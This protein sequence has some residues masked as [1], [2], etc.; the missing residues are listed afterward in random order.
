[1]PAKTAARRKAVARVANHAQ[2]HPDDAAGRRLLRRDL[3]AAVLEERAAELTAY[4]K[5]AV[6]AAPPLTSEQR[7]RLRALL[8]P[9]V[10]LTEDGG[11]P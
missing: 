5:A 2:N 7:A 11:A 6:A 10:R 3:C 9:A 1:M 4:I 8:T